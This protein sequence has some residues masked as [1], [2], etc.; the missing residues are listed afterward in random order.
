M[1]KDA[2]KSWPNI[3]EYFRLSLN[4]QLPE[5]ASVSKV[6]TIQNDGVLAYCLDSEL[7]PYSG[8]T[9]ER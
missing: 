8:H 3:C 7:S 5:L 9:A 1:T 6:I 2:S 4:S